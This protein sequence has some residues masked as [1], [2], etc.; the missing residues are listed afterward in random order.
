[1]KRESE[2]IEEAKAKEKEQEIEIAKH[3]EQM[4]TKK[5]EE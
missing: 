1:M 4:V 3:R 2:A 5:I